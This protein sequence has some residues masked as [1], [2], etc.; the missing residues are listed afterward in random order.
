MRALQR[1]LEK[2][3]MEFDNVYEDARR[4]E[5]YA[6][7][8]FPGTYYLAYRDLPAI[9][10]EHVR[11]RTALDFGCGTGRSTRF[12]K[13]LGF[14]A[15]GVDI[16][17]DMLKQARAIDPEGHY[18]LIEDG[19]VNRREAEAYDLVLAVFTFDNIATMEKK[20]ALFRDLGSLLGKEGRI[21]SVVSSPD[22]YIHEWASFTTKDFP[23]NRSARSGD[24][25][26]IVMTDVEDQRP[27]E[28]IIWTDEAYR[29][30][31]RHAGLELVKKFAPLARASEP[32]EWVSE[33][34]VAPWVIYVLKEL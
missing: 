32:Y 19:S 17:E 20:V 14:D 23:E 15:V 2:T 18:R 12:L 13:E 16:A 3:T 5:A 10:S 1:Y 11:G 8:E 6:K 9:I 24:K 25:V 27:V 28:D 7:L 4:A 31:Y 22:I 29:E 21:V 34:K 30:V 33:T 26:Q